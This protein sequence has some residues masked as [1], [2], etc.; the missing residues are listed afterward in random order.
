MPSLIHDRSFHPTPELPI[1]ADFIMDVAGSR[2]EAGQVRDEVAERTQKR[3]QVTAG[4]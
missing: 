1:L 3:F 2:I 4:L